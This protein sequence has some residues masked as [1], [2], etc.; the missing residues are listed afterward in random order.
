MKRGIDAIIDG[1]R[2]SECGPMGVPG[3]KIRQ[4]QGYGPGPRVSALLVIDGT[5]AEPPGC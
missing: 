3:K 2:L 4:P 5:G 1:G